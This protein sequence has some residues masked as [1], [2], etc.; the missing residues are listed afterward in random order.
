[1]TNHEIA[2]RHREA[3]KRAK[4]RGFVLVDGRWRSRRWMRANRLE[5]YIP[6]K[7]GPTRWIGG[8]LRDSQ[9]I[10]VSSQK[11]KSRRAAALS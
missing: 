4:I 2:A 1:M 8:D 3:N 10:G 5:V 6:A 11:G 9:E 7:R